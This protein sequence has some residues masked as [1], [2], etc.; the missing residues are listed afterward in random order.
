MVLRDLIDRAGRSVQRERRVQPGPIAHDSIAQSDLPG[1]HRPSALPAPSAMA[2]RIVPHGLNVLEILPALRS[3]R[4]DPTAMAIP[5]GLLMPIA[6]AA[7]TALHRAT[8][9]ILLVDPAVVVNGLAA[10]RH[11]A[12]PARPRPSRTPSHPRRAKRH[13]K[14]IASPNC[15]PAPASRHA[16]ISSG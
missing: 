9:T 11:R 5:I 16:A 2:V 3:G 7:R 15:L 10:W 13:M 4:R 1:L 12:L 6:M 14:A 8:D